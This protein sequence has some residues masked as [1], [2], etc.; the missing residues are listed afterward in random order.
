MAMVTRVIVGPALSEDVGPTLARA[1][2]Q[3]NQGFWTKKEPGFKARKRGPRPENG[4]TFS[5]ERLGFSC[6]PEGIVIARPIAGGPRG[7]P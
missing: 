1:L 6:G 5:P 3:K 2:G 7:R 4:T